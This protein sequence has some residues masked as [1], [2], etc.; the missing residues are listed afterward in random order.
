MVKITA[1][2]LVKNEEAF[3]EKCIN[4]V[5]WCDEIIV[6]DDY[7]TDNSV[8]IA[9]K[10]G[11]KVF[12]RH[13]DNNFANQRN[14][15]LGLAHNSWVL[16]IDADEVV[17]LKLKSSIFSKV[18]S[19]FNN[20]YFVK[21]RNIFMGKQL[22]FGEWGN[23]YLLRLGKKGTGKWK[24]AVHE[25]WDIKPAGKLEGLLIHNQASSISKILSKLTLYTKLHAN[26]NLK[27]SKGAGMWKIFLFP[28]GKFISNFVF[29]KGYKDG[30]H[31]FIL[32]VLISFHSFLSWGQIWLQKR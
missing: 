31:G 17:S 24:R 2:I 16:F 29:R 22:H 19:S 9:K 21:R 32:S 28:I 27:E 30:T 11:A 18:G 15:A 14:F 13:L 26:E 20:G 6:I 10:Y 3:L 5:N 25:Y 1:V 7:S 4:S 12:R 23:S 8:L